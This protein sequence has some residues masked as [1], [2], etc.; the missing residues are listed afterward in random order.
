M[1]ELSHQKEQALVEKVAKGMILVSIPT[2]F[3]LRYVMPSP[4]GKTLL[5]KQRQSMLGPLFPPR[6][7]WF[8]FECPNLYW[9]FVCWKETRRELDI[10]TANQVLLS[11]FVLHYIQRA[12]LYPL[13]LSTNT[14]P[15]PFAVVLSAFLFCNVNG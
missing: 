5:S 6:L 10:H 4:W 3:V 14:K 2:F 7:S 13:I 9:S 12:I 15:I 1:F 8:L 11:L